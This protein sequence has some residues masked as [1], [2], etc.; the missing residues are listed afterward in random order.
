MVLSSTNFDA[1]DGRLSRQVKI[2][3]LKRAASEDQ[4]YCMELLLEAGA[5]ITRM[6]FSGSLE[7]TL[8][9]AAMG[10]QNRA[11]RLLLDMS[12]TVDEMST[13]RVTLLY[14]AV[15]LGLSHTV[16]LLLSHG[17]DPNLDRVEA[18]KV[19]DIWCNMKA[20]L[21]GGFHKVC[22]WSSKSALL[23]AMD[24]GREDLVTLLQEYGVT[25]DG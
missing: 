23:R 19:C 11:I 18:F 5:P 13:T 2:D 24:E 14:W 6:S 25:V 21:E 15:E 9:C 16:A 8:I 17:V 3:A 22:P 1:L 10:G 7:S 4:V 12:A 20:L